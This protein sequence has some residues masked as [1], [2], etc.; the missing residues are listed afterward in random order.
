MEDTLAEGADTPASVPRSPEDDY[1]AGIIERRR[2]LIE[3]QSG[4]ALKHVVHYSVDPHSVKGNC[5]NFV[6]VAQ[7][8]IGLAGP[9]H[10]CGEHAQGDFLIPLATTEGTL[11]AS[12]NRG[13]KVLNLCGGVTVTVVADAMQRAPAFVFQDARAGREFAHWVQANLATIRGKA[14][15]TSS[16]ARLQGIDS[17]LAS[18]FVYLRFNFPPGTRPGRTWSAAPPWR[19]ASGFWRNIRESR[20]SS[21]NR[22]SQRTRR[23]RISTGC[24][25]GASGSLQRP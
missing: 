20:I 8:P 17:Y 12:Y 4:V 23:L 18:K 14:E 19:P 21:W 22:T 25:R 2:L 3:K 10:V 5:E 11:V 13:I 16:V 1:D 6:G 9:L 15:A 24:A 7:V